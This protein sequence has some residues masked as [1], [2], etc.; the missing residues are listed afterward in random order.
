MSQEKRLYLMALVVLSS[1]RKVTLRLLIWEPQK[2][3]NFVAFC[4]NIR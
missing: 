3:S 4:I 2:V 1:G